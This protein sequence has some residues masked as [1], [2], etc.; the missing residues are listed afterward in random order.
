MCRAWLACAASLG[1]LGRRRP[2]G[3]T[4]RANFGVLVKLVPH[5]LVH[6]EAVREVSGGFLKIGRRRCMVKS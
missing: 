5:L 1:A 3:E 2:E 6:L 4:V